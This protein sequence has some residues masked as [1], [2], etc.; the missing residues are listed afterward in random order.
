MVKFFLIQK[1]IKN[2]SVF[3][4]TISLEKNEKKRKK[5][6][7]IENLKYQITHYIYT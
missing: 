2:V 7:K 6:K 3:N 1:I 4:Y 5:M